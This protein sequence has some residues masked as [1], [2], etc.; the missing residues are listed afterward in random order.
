MFSQRASVLRYPTWPA[1]LA[2]RCL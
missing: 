1:L 2:S